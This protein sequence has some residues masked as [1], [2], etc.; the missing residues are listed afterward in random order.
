MI[1]EM[2]EYI[3]TTGKIYRK[4]DRGQQRENIL[5][6]LTTLHSI[7]TVSELIARTNELWKNMKTYACLPGT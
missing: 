6:S 2:F 4:R 3:V 1:R 5:Y 7:K